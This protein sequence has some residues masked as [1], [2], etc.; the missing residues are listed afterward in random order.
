M[1][2]VCA[3]AIAEYAIMNPAHAEVEYTLDLERRLRRL[4]WVVQDEIYDLIHD[5][6]Q[7]SSDAFRRRDWK[8]VVLNQVPGG[9]ITEAATVQE[10][11]ASTGGEL[12]K[13]PISR[14]RLGLRGIVSLAFI[15]QRWRTRKSKTVE[16]PITEYRL[17]LR[18]T[19]TKVN[20]KGWRYHNRY[21]RPWGASDADEK[22]TGENNI[23]TRGLRRRDSQFVSDKCIKLLIT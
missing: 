20:E 15:K 23:K 2:S 4:D 12:G 22:E 11:Q 3:A 16:M 6:I 8:L 5:R 7:S 10:E 17:I 9:E 13:R 1:E 14:G 19:E 21:S 18:G